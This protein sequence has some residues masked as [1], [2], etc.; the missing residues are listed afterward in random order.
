MF[1][2]LSWG[3]GGVTLK[4]TADGCRV[5]TAFLSGQPWLMLNKSRCNCQVH[6]IHSETRLWIECI[7]VSRTVLQEGRGAGEE[8][9]GMCMPCC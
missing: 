8:G 3:G 2:F 9:M 7:I 4:L 5:A 1:F 6:R